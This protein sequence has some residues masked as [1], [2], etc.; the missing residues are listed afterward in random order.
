M[1]N[2]TADFD[3]WY[4]TA[5]PRVLAAVQVVCGFHDAQDATHT[6]FVRALEKWDNVQQME[7]PSRWVAQVAI[8]AAKRSYLRSLRGRA[9]ETRTGAKPT[10]VDRYMDHD[11]W[12]SVNELPTRQRQAVALRYIFDYDQKRI[13]EH[14]GVS[15][16]TAA[17]TLHQARATLRS[18]PHLEGNDGTIS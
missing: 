18:S 13:A 7:S 16:G 8:N 6:G 17:A 9:L 14:L 3:A 10:A 12:A 5:Y 4:A 15:G 1:V 11:L 2:G